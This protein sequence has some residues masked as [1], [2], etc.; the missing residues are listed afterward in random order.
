M[1]QDGRTE[2]PTP[3]KRQDMRKE[4]RILS[5]PIFLSA[6]QIFV[7]IQL[8]GSK[9]PELWTSISNM[10]RATLRHPELRPAQYVAETMQILAGALLIP[11]LAVS[12]GLGAHL[13]LSSGL[14]SFAG[15]SRGPQ[16]HFN[17]LQRLQNV[18]GN[19]WQTFLLALVSTPLLLAVAGLWLFQ[20]HAYQLEGPALSFSASKVV[21]LDAVLGGTTSMSWLILLVGVVDLIRQKQRFDQQSM[22]TKQEVRDEHRE[23]E[24]RPEVKA[25]LRKLR[26]DL[27]RRRMMSDVSNANVVITNPTHYAVALTYQLGQVG[28]PKVIAK[29]KNYLA[30]R[31]RERAREAGVPIIENPPVSRA[32]YQSTEVGQEIPP[33]LYRAV[34]EILAYVHRVGRRGR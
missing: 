23:S 8:L 16:T 3:K 10:L 31:I 17:P 22:M 25:Q 27:L 14:I 6:L 13:I 11:L 4:G 5:S 15:L 30:A 18:Y 24:G 20:N 21:A 2:K 7:L 29:G 1:A 33:V 12:A 32:L 9:L 34:A 28:A 19:A 26:R